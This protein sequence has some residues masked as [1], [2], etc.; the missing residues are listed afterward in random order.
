MAQTH[1]VTLIPGDG[2]GPEISQATQR[3]IDATGVRIEWEV[4]EAGEAMIAKA[5]NPLPEEVVES[6]RRNKVALKGPITTPIGKGFRSVNVALRKK[7]KALEVRL[8][9]PLLVRTTRRVALSEAGAGF[10]ARVG[11]AATE[12]GEALT[13][14]GT[15][16]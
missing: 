8:G 4:M 11:P 6:I 12:I 16:R 9:L 14:F 13:L 7:L 15:S 3:V 2:I 1:R 5:G 10:L